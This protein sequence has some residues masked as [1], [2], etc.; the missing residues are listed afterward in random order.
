[1]KFDWNDIS[2]VPAVLSDINSRTE[3]NP[4]YKDKLPIFLA[5]MDMVVDEQNAQ[6][7]H[8]AGINVCMPRHIKDINSEY[9]ISYGLEEIEDILNS[10]NPKLPKR[11]LID[12]ANGHIKKLYDISERIKSRFGNGI[13]LM[14][15]NIA[16]PLTYEAYCQMGVCVDYIRVGIGGG[17]ACTTSANTGVHYPMA[18]LVYECHE[19]SQK[20]SKS[21]KIVADGGFRNFSDITKAL[22]LGADYVM[23]GGIFSKCFE[24]CSS[25]FVLED[26]A[27]VYV[28]NDDAK[29]IYEN[30]LQK[31]YKYYRGMSTKEVQKK[32]NKSVLKTSEGIYKFNEVEYTLSGWVDNFV[33]YLKTMM[34]YCNKRTLN[35]FV[36]QVEYVLITNNAFNRFNK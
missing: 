4:F 11:V 16:N 31:L 17:S 30:K 8:N 19:I 15:G 32:W 3:I 23:L 2:V 36:G 26:D 6:L 24:S 10:D 1:M 5:P 25:F 12:I 33:H 29:I 22:A 13:E 18:S 34:S 9:F 14:I 35:D 27:F 7:F 20:Y 21:P 28:N